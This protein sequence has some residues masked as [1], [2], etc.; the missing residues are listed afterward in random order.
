MNTITKICIAAILASGASGC[1]Y[2]SETMTEVATVEAT[3]FALAQ[4]GIGTGSGLDGK[5]RMTTTT[6]I[7]HLPSVYGV[8][9]RCP[10]GR[11]AVQGEGEKYKTLWGR[12][13]VGDQVIVRYKEIRDSDG[14]LIGYDF[15]SAQKTVLDGGSQ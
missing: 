6:E 12:F 4:T 8:V 15:L 7:V 14:V 2:Y 1:R 9:L 3:P 13:D 10:H 11:F 5:G